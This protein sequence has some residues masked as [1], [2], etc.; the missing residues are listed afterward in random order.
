MTIE[1]GG[2]TVP[3]L[4]KAPPATMEPAPIRQPSM[5]VAPMPIRQASPISQPCRVTWCVI[6]Q[7]APTKV[8][9]PAPTWIITKS[10]MLARGPI[11]TRSLS[12]RTTT[13]HQ[14]EAPGWISTAPYSRAEGSI[15]AA[16]RSF[17]SGPRK[18]PL[19]CA[20]VLPSLSLQRRA[21]KRLQAP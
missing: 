2:I 6:E 9:V 5:M 7:S 15:Q 20:S 3:S 1:Q 10:W 12:A 19:M 13:L 17:T 8:P 11:T 14:T 16:P 4:R 18:G 21:D